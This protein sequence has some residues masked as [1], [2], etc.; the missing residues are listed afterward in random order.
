MP[1]KI[2]ELAKELDIGPLDLVESLKAKGFAVRNHMAELSDADVASY[3]ASVKK[4]EAST[5]DSSGKK[6]VVR[7]KAPAVAA[8][9]VC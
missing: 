5:S 4:D 7:K 3:L 1:K 8:K 6:K 2:F 9:T